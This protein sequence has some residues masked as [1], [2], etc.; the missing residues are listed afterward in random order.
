[1][2]SPNLLLLKPKC[3]V[4]TQVAGSITDVTTVTTVADAFAPI[5]TQTARSTAA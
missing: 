4:A 2:A 3:I 1:M 5:D